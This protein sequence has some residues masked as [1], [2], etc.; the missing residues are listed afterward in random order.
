MRGFNGIK[1]IDPSEVGADESATRFAASIKGLRTLC[2]LFIGLHSQSCDQGTIP[3]SK[4]LAKV[5]AHR[6]SSASDGT[7]GG[8]CRRSV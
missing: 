2:S 3:S 1:V 7:S 5:T 6:Q 8:F 4:E